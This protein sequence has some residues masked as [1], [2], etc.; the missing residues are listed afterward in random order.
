MQ[1]LTIHINFMSRVLISY[2]KVFT[3]YGWVCKEIEDNTLV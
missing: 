3:I 1:I 2:N